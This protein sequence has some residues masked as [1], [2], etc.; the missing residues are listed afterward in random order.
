VRVWLDDERDPREWLPNVRWFRNRNP[1]EMAQWMWA[2][3]A[4]EA[5]ALL[6]SE[7]VEECS[8]DH[9]LG[10]PEEAGDGYMVLLAIERRAAED[11]NYTPP[12]IHIHTSNIGARDRMESAVIG[13]ERIVE[14]RDS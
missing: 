2:R 6:E 8:L 9:D 3:T 5:I 14:G 10:P 4:Q 13:I 11:D 12:I 1:E 7:H